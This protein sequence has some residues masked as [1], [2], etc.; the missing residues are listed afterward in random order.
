[1]RPIAKAN[2]PKC[3]ADWLEIQAREGLTTAYANFPEKS[4]LREH[5]IEEQA[6][7]CAY[8]GRQISPSDSCVEHLKPQSLCRTEKEESGTVVGDDV[9]HLNMVAAFKASGRKKDLYGEACRQNWYGPKYVSPVEDGCGLH[10]DFDLNGTITGVTPQGEEMISRLKL[11]HRILNEDRQA[12]ILKA[13]DSLMPLLQLGYSLE[14][15]LTI[16]SQPV[17]GRLPAFAF[18]I[19]KALP[20]LQ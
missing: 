18:V 13:T 15:F 20:K 12:A 4:P 1:M 14:Q 5:L 2:G 9:N 10:F 11:D 8:T 3:L 17:H 6:G 19:E 7:L 16:F